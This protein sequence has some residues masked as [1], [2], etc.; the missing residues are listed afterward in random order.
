MKTVKAWNSDFNGNCTGEENTSRRKKHS[1]SN[2]RDKWLYKKGVGKEGSRCFAEPTGNIFETGPRGQKQEEERELRCGALK[3][4][5]ESGR[6][7]TKRE[8]VHRLGLK[9]T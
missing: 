5:A 3:S 2:R 8:V 9:S 1:K 4:S 6:V 7:R